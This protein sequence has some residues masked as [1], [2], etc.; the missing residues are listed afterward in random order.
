MGLE[1]MELGFS[2][3]TIAQPNCRPSLQL[4]PISLPIQPNKTLQDVDATPGGN[5]L[6]LT[7]LAQNFKSHGVRDYRK[8]SGS[9]EQTAR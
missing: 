7:N 1:P 4:S 2:N 3:R 8:H 9:T 6:D 5:G